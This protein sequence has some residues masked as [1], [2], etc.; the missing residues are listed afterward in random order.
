VRYPD[1][2]AVEGG[3][4]IHRFSRTASRPQRPTLLFL[5]IPKTA[6]TAFREAIM[7]NYRQSEVMYI[8]GDPPGFPSTYLGDIPLSQR[9]RLR[10]V[11]GHVGYG[12]HCHMPHPCD[13]AALIRDPLMRIWSHYT[14]L[15]RDNDP[16]AVRSGKPMD[17]EEVL[18]AK[19]SVHL[20]NLYVRY[21]CGIEEGE[22]P[23]GTIN[24]ELYELASAHT[25]QPN[26]FVGPQSDLESAYQALAE[27]QDWIRGLECPRLNTSPNPALLPSAKQERAI[28]HFNAWDFKLYESMSNLARNAAR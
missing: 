25:R 6:G 11:F 14:H 15:V 3:P 20:D 16:A 26:V 8:Y 13:Y 18:A 17:I 19:R 1:G 2:S 27:K 22:I 28:R 21:F 4:I 5:H 7:P 23:P 24:R 12:G 9:A 10:L